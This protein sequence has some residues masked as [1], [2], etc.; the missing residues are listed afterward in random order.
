[1]KIQWPP[2]DKGEKLISEV[3]VFDY[4]FRLFFMC[5]SA[6]Y[7]AIYELRRGVFGRGVY[8]MV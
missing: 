6:R 3:E 1:M 4:T 7:V 5:T 8:W 2:K